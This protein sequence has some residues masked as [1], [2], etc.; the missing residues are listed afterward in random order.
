[1]RS[2]PVSDAVGLLKLNARTEHGDF[3]HRLVILVADEDIC[4]RSGLLVHRSRDR[5]AKLL[6]TD[7]PVI[8]YSGQH[9]AVYNTNAHFCSSFLG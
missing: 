8:L 2:P 5:H 6:V 1:M 3:E 4:D 9:P 7:T